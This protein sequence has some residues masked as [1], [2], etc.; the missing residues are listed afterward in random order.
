V[1]QTVK[2]C[3]KFGRRMPAGSPAYEVRNQVVAD[4]DG[5]MAGAEADQDT[6]GQ[7]Q[8]LVTR[9]AARDPDE[10]MREVHHSERH[11][12]CPGCRDRYLANPLNLAVGEALP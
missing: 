10:L 3:E 4:F 9:M 1:F 7:I 12:V 5:A 8:S 11:F 2:C 6:R